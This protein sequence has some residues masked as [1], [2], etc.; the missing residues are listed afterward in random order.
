LCFHRIHLLFEKNP[1]RTITKY[2][3]HPCADDADSKNKTDDEIVPSTVTLSAAKGLARWASRCFAALSMTASSRL[4]PPTSVTLSR[5][6][7]SVPLGVEMLRF[8]QHDSTVTYTASRINV[9]H[10]IIAPIARK[11]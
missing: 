10:C 8:A 2:S 11:K 6:E 7:G 3:V 4:L 9:F 5:S 1:L